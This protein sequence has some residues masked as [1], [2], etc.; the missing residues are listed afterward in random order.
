MVSKHFLKLINHE[1]LPL[2]NPLKNDI[3][4]NNNTYPTKTKSNNEKNSTAIQLFNAIMWLIIIFDAKP[5][6]ALFA[7]KDQIETYINNEPFDSQIKAVNT[8]IKNLGQSK[9]LTQ[10]IL[11]LKYKNNIRNNVCDFRLLENKVIRLKDN[12]GNNIKSFF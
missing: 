6:T 10:L 5:D 11:E 4:K 9:T 12:D 8:I 7:L 3:V 1:G 2:F